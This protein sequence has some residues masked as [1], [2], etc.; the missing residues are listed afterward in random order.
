LSIEPTLD[1]AVVAANEAFYRAFNER[2]AAAMSDL[3]ANDDAVTCIHPHWNVL[4]GRE[5]VLESWRAILGNP[6]QPKLVSAVERTTLRGE[7]AIVVGRELAAGHPIAVTN[8]FVRQEGAWKM[9]H[10]HASPVA[11][12]GM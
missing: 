7:I 6:D 12:R 11:P 9:L 4:S 3:W 8:T 5:T 1:A 10:H 2:D